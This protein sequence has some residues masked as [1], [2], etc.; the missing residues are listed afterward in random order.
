MIR[1]PC[2]K[3]VGSPLAGRSRPAEARRE[4]GALIQ[5]KTHEPKSRINAEIPSDRE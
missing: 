1:C 2:A 4:P 5:I 3:V